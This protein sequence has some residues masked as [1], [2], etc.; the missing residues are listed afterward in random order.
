MNNSRYSEIDYKA[1]LCIECRKFFLRTLKKDLKDLKKRKKRKKKGNHP[2]C[3][4][5][6]RLD[7]KTGPDYA[8]VIFE[9][10]YEKNEYSVTKI[11]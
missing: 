5:R 7:E 1:A 3:P 8:V 10:I 2:D 9:G 6:E 11:M 4:R